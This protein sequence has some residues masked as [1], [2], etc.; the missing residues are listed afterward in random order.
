MGTFQ[1]EATPARRLK[2]LG[3]WN[4]LWRVAGGAIVTAVAVDAVILFADWL[5]VVPRPAVGFPSG[6]LLEVP[7]ASN[8]TWSTLADLAAWG[9]AACVATLVVTCAVS[10]G[11][12][13]PVSASRV[14]VILLV[15]A[16]FLFHVGHP[17]SAG[18]AT[19]AWIV[20]SLLIW[21]FALVDEA[22]PRRRQAAFMGCLAVAFLAT[23]APYGLTHPLTLA[24]A[25]PAV[26]RVTQ[27]GVVQTRFELRNAGFT[28]VRVSDVR[29]ADP[30]PFVY[31]APASASAAFSMP[32]HTSAFVALRMRF[33]G[34]SPG[35]RFR[36]DRVL[37]DYRVLG[38][39]FTAPVRLDSPLTYRCG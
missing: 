30:W 11:S 32:G 21:R 4:V 10:G 19:V 28:G 17:S 31:P 36:L 3:F 2:P 27:G 29:P 7:F 24:V 5:G 38:L 23:I 35:S 15:S 16:P 25:A 1:Y 26:I 39:D 6:G 12:G 13:R 18:K 22:W 9:L 20:A 33:R 34:C 8:G 14:F 37:V